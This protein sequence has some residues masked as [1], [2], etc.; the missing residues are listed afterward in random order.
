[1][2]AESL[3]AIGTLR[4]TFKQKPRLITMHPDDPQRI[5]ILDGERLYIWHGGQP[6]KI[7]VLD[8][9]AGLTAEENNLIMLDSQSGLLYRT[10][11]E[12]KTPVQLS[13]EKIEHD[14]YASIA[15]RSDG[16][17]VSNGSGLWFL[18]TA[19][20]KVQKLAEAPSSQNIL[21]TDTN[22]IWWSENELWI[23]WLASDEDLPY[24]QTERR[25]KIMQTANPI[26][27]VFHY[28]GEE[29]YLI[30]AAGET[31]SITEL[32]GRD[33]RNTINLYK[34][35]A[36]RIFIPA[37]EKIVYILDDNI[38]LKVSLDTPFQTKSN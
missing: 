19:A 23:Q 33:K 32:D 36:P 30:V 21:S 13:Q 3:Y 10:D 18:D 17:L 37:D 14:G 2:E 7:P 15:H 28:P 8:T 12:G 5:F 24:Y 31:V 34:G 29:E 20:S 35:K 27:Q 22:V 4:R 6:P 26:S 9:I 16:Y 1:V 25:E 11:L 38:L